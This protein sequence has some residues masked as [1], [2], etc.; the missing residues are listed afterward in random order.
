MKFVNTQCS[1]ST[2]WRRLHWLSVKDCGSVNGMHNLYDNHV[3]L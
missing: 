1:L 2:S 3:F